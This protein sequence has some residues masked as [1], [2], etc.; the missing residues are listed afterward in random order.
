MRAPSRVVHG[1]AALLGRPRLDRMLGDVDVVWLPAPAPVAVGGTPYVLTLHDLSFL[2]RPGDYTRYERL[3]HRLARVGPLA[4]R[5][6]RVVAV[7][8]ATAA[9][10]RER[11]GVD[12][13]IVPAGPGDP[14]PLDVR[15]R[16]G[17]LLPLC[18]CARAAQGSWTSSSPRTKGSHEELVLAG[19][20]HRRVSRE[21]KAALYAGALAVV[22]PSW[23]EGYGYTPL[24]AYAHGTPAI[25]SDLPALRE[26]AGEGAL[27]VPPGDVAALRA[28]MRS[29]AGDSAATRASPRRRAAPR[30]LHGRSWAASAPGV[31]RRAR[32]G[33]GVTFTAVIVL[34]DSEAELRAL[35]DSIDAYLPEPPQLVAVDSGSRDGGPDLAAR[36]RR[37]GGR[38]GRQPRLRRGQQRRARAGAAR[39][40]GAAEPRLRAARRLAGTRSPRIAARASRRAARAAAAQRR[41]Q[42]PALG[43]PAARHGRRAAARA[44]APAAAARA[45]LR[46]RAEPYRASAT[47]HRRLGDRRVPGRR[48]TDAARARP[49]RPG[50]PPVRRGH[51][52]RAARPRRGIPTVLHPQLRI[53]HTGGHATQRGGEPF[54]LLARR[55]RE[56]IAGTLGTARAARSTTRPRRSRSPPAPRAA[57]CSAATRRGRARSSPRCAGQCGGSHTRAASGRP[58]SADR[59]P[60]SGSAA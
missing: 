25:V 12:A 29:L 43:A 10:A 51:G 44:R 40:H 32:R 33:C 31:A 27:Y 15:P 9:A 1:A 53:R 48:D 38:A 20:G 49:V 14:G 47:A 11:L 50:R 59:G 57:P 21:E 45:P 36:A 17:R 19:E 46:D 5:A 54:E 18:R 56:A 41:R 2:E 7:S 24:E 30:A 34:H 13:V 8:G 55:R 60:R 58:A 26:T 37:R 22:L 6:A 16:Q 23:C 39:R 3:W 4:R 42:R 35:L 52:A 28:A